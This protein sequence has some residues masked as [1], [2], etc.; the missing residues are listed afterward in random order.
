MF[1][2]FG[3][4]KCPSISAK[5]VKE[6]LNTDNFLLVDVRSPEEYASGHIEKS[7]T[8]PLQILATEIGKVA[9][10]KDTEIVVYC[11]SGMRSSKACGQLRSMG[12]EK[13]SN[14]GAVS[15]WPEPLVR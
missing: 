1:E 12:Y 10:N 5:E 7:V 14:L 15:S 9:P 2:L 13:V 6:K 4:H 11:L 3:H 8:L